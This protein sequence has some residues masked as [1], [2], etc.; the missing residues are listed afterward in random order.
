MNYVV[1]IKI[2]IVDIADAMLIPN[3]LIV[4]FMSAIS[5]SK[6]SDV[7]S[8]ISFNIHANFVEIG[9]QMGYF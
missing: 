6:Y 1:H 9:I 4:T 5:F 8:L 7:P 2:A 3:T